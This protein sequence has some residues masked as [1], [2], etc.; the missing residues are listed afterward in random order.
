MSALPRGEEL[1]YVLQRRVTKRLPVPDSRLLTRVEA[2][3]EHARRYGE[4]TGA[5][6]AVARAYEFGAGWE[7]IVPLSLWTLGVE[8]HVLIHIAPHARLELVNH[9]LERFARLPDQ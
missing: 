3:F 6:I 8:R 9:V 1:N 7:L 5:D 2:A 4:A